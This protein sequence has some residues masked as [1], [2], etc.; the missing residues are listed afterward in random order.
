PVLADG[1]EDSPALEPLRSRAAA[2]VASLDGDGTRVVGLKDPRLS[3]TLPFWRTVTP[4]THVVHCL[5]NPVE[6]AGSF[7]RWHPLSVEQAGELWLRYVVGACRAA[8]EQLLVPFDDVLAGPAAVAHR[9]AAGVGLPDP[10]SDRLAEVEACVHSK[11][12]RFR[13]PVDDLGP[14]ALPITLYRPL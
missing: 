3:L 2:V 12:H 6:A 5:R 11:L 7:S 14:L 13:S 10:S 1:W 8:R 9:I 4:V